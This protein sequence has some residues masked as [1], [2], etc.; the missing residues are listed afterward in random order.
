VEKEMNA[1]GHSDTIDSSGVPGK[2][3]VGLVDQLRG[4][5]REL[6]RENRE[7]LSVQSAIALTASSLDLQFVLENVTWELARLLKV[8]RCVIYDLSP[9][10]RTLNHVAEY[11][12]S[13]SAAD[14]QSFELVEFPIRERVLAEKYAWQSVIEGP[15]LDSAEKSYMIAEGIK[16][17][18]LIPLVFQESIVG[19]IEASDSQ[20]QRVFSDRKVSLAQMLSTQVAAGI[21]NARLYRRSEEEIVRRIEVE[22]Q[23]RTSLE[24][25]EVLL[26]EIHHRVK[27]NLQTVSSILNLQSRNIDNP[28]VLA[29]FRDSQARVRTMAMIHEK[30]YRSDDLNRINFAEY[31]HSLASYL[32]RSYQIPSRMVY[33]RMEPSQVRL[34]IDSAVP[35]GLIINEL[36][37]NSLKYAFPPDNP[38]QPATMT[39]KQRDEIHIALTPT[40]DEQLCLIVSDNGVGFPK[41]IDFRETQSLGL[42]LVMTLTDQLGGTIS[43]AN[44]DGTCWEII[45][46]A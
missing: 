14:A 42:R 46:P 23:L 17:L 16:T 8:E 22:E 15:E 12:S 21:E 25:K 4:R 34:S 10:H 30:L 33:L 44:K 31:G 45:F 7:L 13:G 1:V 3:A 29:V 32:I 9:D 39:G 27:N 35:C 38:D 41:E 6:E 2:N 24:E 37:T 20:D 11:D 26:K 36:V 28:V 43:L 40:S 19:L 5:I 18:L